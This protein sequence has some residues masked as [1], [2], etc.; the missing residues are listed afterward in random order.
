MLQ[1]PSAQRLVAARRRWFALVVVC[2]AQLMNTLDGTIVNVA[3]PS[4]QADLHF[5]QANLTWVVNGY[6]ITFG[7]F[8]LFAGRLG[9]LIG[10]KRVFIAGV[11]LFTVASAV[12][13]VAHDQGVLVAARLVQGV[14]GAVS[15]SVI[16]AIIVT[17]FSDPAARTRAMSTY[18]FTAVGGGSIGLLLGG[19]L[20]QSIDWHWIFFINV[21]IGLAAVMLGRGL[22][23]DTHG[24]GLGQG[25]DVLGSVLMTLA[26]MGATFAIVQA[27]SNGWTSPVTLGLLVTATLLLATFGLLQQRLANPIMPL[28]IL[29]VGGLTSSSAVRGLAA[30]GMFACFFLG[31]LY[32]NRILDFG[33]VQTGLAFLPMTLT[34]GSL[35]LGATARLSERFGPRACTSFGLVFIVASLAL[36]AGADEQTAYFPRL[37]LAF[38]LLGL[39]A[40]MSF[41]PLLTIALAD[42]PNEDAGLAS[43]I[44]NVSMQLSAALGLAVLGSLSS[45]RTA[46]L[47]GQGM[48]LN[49]AL[50]DG[51]HLSFA[52]A[53][54]CVSLG[55]LAA[56]VLLRSPAAPAP[57]DESV[58]SIEGSDSRWQID[59]AA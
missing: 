56:L 39:G 50:I 16:V 55:L 9:D 3:L 26:V 44:V 31:S 4:I 30:M 38:G 27:P 17:E 42:V 47:V 32:L 5:S 52:V 21:P 8:L 35:S 13:G 28:R 46:D 51:F 58:P 40:G 45:Q 24:L 22:L 48:S 23:Q 2:L 15:S 54:V 6:L 19:L 49:A 43:G 10:R 37:F 29:R 53:G 20:T 34:V 33:P 25:I 18:I 12:S 1:F 7:S 59:R 14:G 57:N 11:L 36:L 41:M